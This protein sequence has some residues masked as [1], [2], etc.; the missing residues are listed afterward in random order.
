MIFMIR[1]FFVE[2]EMKILLKSL[3]CY[4]EPVSEEEDEDKEVNNEDEDVNIGRN[5]EGYDDKVFDTLGAS[6]ES[7]SITVK[8]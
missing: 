8:R 3:G 4:N 6:F 1:E 5:K 2:L 7:P